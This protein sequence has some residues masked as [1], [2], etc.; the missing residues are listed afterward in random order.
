MPD[1]LISW[2][3]IM[4]LVCSMKIPIEDALKKPVTHSN[5]L[6]EITLLSL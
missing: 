3:G 6:S 4:D 1:F 5:T 2:L